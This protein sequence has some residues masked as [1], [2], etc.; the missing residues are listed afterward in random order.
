VNINVLD[1]T[2]RSKVHLAHDS[3]A[4]DGTFRVVAPAGTFDVQYDAPAC[5]GDAPAD[6]KA[7]VVVGPTTLATMQ[8]VTGAHA[9]GTVT[10]D[11]T[12]Q[13]NVVGSVDL[14]FFVPGT[15]IKYYTP[16]DNTK[17][18]GSYDVLVQPATYDIEF[19]PPAG[20]SLRPARRINQGVPFDTTLPNVVLTTGISVSGT[21]HAQ[22]TGVP[23]A[24]VAVDFFAPGTSSALLV[25]HN[26]SDVVGSFS[27]AVD[28]GTWDLYYDP[29]TGTGLAPRWRRG[30]V[31]LAP[32]AVGDTLLL[33][34][35]APGVSTVTPASGTTAGGQSLTITGTA[36]QPDAAVTIGGVAAT[37]VVVASPTT[38][39]AVTPHHPAGAADVAVVNP[40]SQSGTMP[41]AY[42]FLEPPNGV[43]ITVVRSGNDLVLTW[44]AAA[45][46]SY[47]VYR[48]TASTGFGGSNVL[49]TTTGTSYTDVGAAASV[50]TFYYQVD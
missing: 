6:Q 26:D 50:S 37:G 39:T 33:P 46:S 47:T 2:T 30:V 32:T 17:A 21:V 15:R 49:A 13:P 22:A 35:T 45:Q 9:M 34:L 19:T 38:L 4:L 28:P 5:T 44:P 10:D 24:G 25:A 31:A 18:D 48:N 43:R 7:V 8:L 41:A 27:V 12:P 29:P 20:S 16:G 42:T 1:S 14:D 23:V 40:G 11:A 3:T 36:F